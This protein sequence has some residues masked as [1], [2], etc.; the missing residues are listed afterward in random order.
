M[1]QAILP[2]A[3]IGMQIPGMISARKQEKRMSQKQDAQ[4]A[5]IGEAEQMAKGGPLSEANLAELGKY[6]EQFRAGQAERGLF[7]SGVS[8]AQ[9][10]EVMP[11]MEQRLRDAQV[12]Q[13]LDVAQGYDPILSSQA[14]RMAGGGGGMGGEMMGMGME[15][16]VAGKGEDWW[17]LKKPKPTSF[18]V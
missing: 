10:G 16:L 7:S 12:R 11:Q 8:A 2:L 17:G 18:N 14:A 3:M 4:L 1:P 9:E 13:L 5:R 6:K 15:K